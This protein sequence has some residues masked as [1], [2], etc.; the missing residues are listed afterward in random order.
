MEHTIR[1]LSFVQNKT[2]FISHAQ[3]RILEAVTPLFPDAENFRVYD[4]D[5]VALRG[6]EEAFQSS[7]LVVLGG[8]RTVFIV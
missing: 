2:A 5:K 7:N 1:L 6:L 8:E 3:Q 4:N